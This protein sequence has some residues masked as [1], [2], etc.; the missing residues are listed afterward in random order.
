MHNQRPVHLMCS[1]QKS[2]DSVVCEIVSL[3]GE[4]VVEKLA[5]GAPDVYVM[6]D[7]CCRGGWFDTV[8][9]G[10]VSRLWPETQHQPQHQHNP[11]H[12]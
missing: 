11:T 7:G 12:S 5:G 3:I 4:I 9:S 8:L 10:Q 6:I 1:G 2:E